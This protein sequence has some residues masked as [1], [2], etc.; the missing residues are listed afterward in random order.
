MKVGLSHCFYLG[1]IILLSLVTYATNRLSLR[2]S[3]RA[4][5]S[6]HRGAQVTSDIL[7]LLELSTAD[8][9]IDVCMIRSYP[10][11]PGSPEIVAELGIP[12]GTITRP[13]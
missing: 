2:S 6:S 7:N 9:S 1:V 3:F 11:P 10:T 8:R 12:K 5:Q 4:S 13:S